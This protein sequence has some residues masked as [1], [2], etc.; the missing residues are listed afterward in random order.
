[1]GRIKKFIYIAAAIIIVGSA[2][3]YFFG[4]EKVVEAT[5]TGQ[6][7]RIVKVIRGDLNLNVSADGVIQPINKVEVKSKASGQIEQLNF[8]E[9]QYVEKGELLIVLDQTT[10]KNDYEQAKADLALQEATAKQ[11]ENNHNRSVE[12]FEKGLISEQERDQVNVDLVRARSLLV[13]SRASLSSAEERLRDTRIVAPVSGIILTKNI[14]LGQIISSGVSNV[15]GGT[16]LATIADME[17]VHVET[18]VDEVDIGKIRVDHN[19]SIKADAFPD[20]NF[21]GQVIRISPLG[22]TQQNVTTFNVIVLVRNL[23][24][25]LKAGMSASVDLEILN[26]RQ[27]LLVPNDALK[28]PQSEQ[29]RAMLAKRK[30]QEGNAD[31]AKKDSSNAVTGT[32]DFANMSPEQIRERMQNMSAEERQKYRDQMR[33]RFQN[34][35]PEER[36]RSISEMAQRFGGLG[37]SGGGQTMIRSEGGAAGGQS[38]PRQRR[39]S[40][41][42]DENEVRNRVTMVKEG[43]EFVLKI[44]KAGP[45]NFDFTEIIE[46]LKE[47]DEIQITTISRAKVQSEEFTQRIRSMQG[48]GGVGGMSGGG[49]R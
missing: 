30:E 44:V 12:L 37:G 15:G 20:D 32:I 7:T 39:Q 14:E 45:S 2:G 33:Q 43:D 38:G 26:R 11:A 49:R 25:K 9:G 22:K 24:G 31:V 13:K 10:A 48:V 27:V 47:G 17:M 21:S 36:Q 19:A 5:P 41:V 6:V 46:G 16:L 8:V 3:Y 35:S 28:D 4:R 34:M 1:M 23:G 29:G 42:S 40:Q 18:N